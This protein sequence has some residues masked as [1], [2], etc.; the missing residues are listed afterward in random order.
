MLFAYDQS[1]PNRCFW[2]KGM[3][4][5]LD[6]IWLDSSKKVV[7]IASDV[8]PNT[9]PRDFCAPESSQFVIELNSGEAERAKIRVG[10]TLQF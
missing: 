2:M 4:F 9:Y 1:A 7:Y 3:R 10:K 5:A 8:R 6:I